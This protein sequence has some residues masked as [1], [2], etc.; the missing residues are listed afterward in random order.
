MQEGKHSHAGVC[1]Y[2]NALLRTEQRF[3]KKEMQMV[4]AD[5]GKFI[6][7]QQG[8]GANAQRHNAL[9]GHPCV[10]FF[11]LSFEP[12]KSVKLGFRAGLRPERAPLQSSPCRSLQTCSLG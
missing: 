7:W 9:L 1:F 10:K 4:C 11:A 3:K 12:G 2:I 5:Q 8:G 6:V